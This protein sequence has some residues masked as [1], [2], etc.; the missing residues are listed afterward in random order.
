MLKTN[1]IISRLFVLFTAIILNACAIMP[2][3]LPD[4]HF[5][6]Q[7]Q[8]D[9]ASVTA[10]QD[11]LDGPVSLYEAI[12]RG[13]KYNLD[14]HLELAEK[15][16]SQ[17]D[18]DVSQYE[19]LPQL[20]SNLNYA[21]RDTF[22]GSASRSLLTGIQSLQTS[23]SSDRDVHSANL[24]LSWNVLDFGISYIRAKQSADRVLMAEEQK[25]RVVN[26]L[27]QD[28]RA[29]YWRAVS[30][31]RLLK[32][33]ETLLIKV[34]EALRDSRQVATERRERPLT[35]LT[36]QRE[37]I[38]IKREL[39]ELRRTLS[40]AKIQLAALMNLAPGEEYSLVIPERIESVKTIDMS[41]QLMEQIALENRPEIRE[42]SYE[43]RINHMES[44]AA[45]LEL[46]PG[47]DLNFGKNY[48]SNSFLFN[49]DWLAYGAQISWNLMNIF[50]LPAQNRMLNAREKVLDAQRLSLS[51]AVLTQVHVSLAQYEY[52]KREFVIANEYYETQEAI[53]EQVS[54]AFMSGSVSNQ[55]LIREEMNMLVSE[56]KYDIAYSDLENSY[57]AIFSALGMDLLPNYSYL[58]PLETL[59]S[60]LK[61]KLS[62]SSFKD[63]VFSLKID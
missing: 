31:D 25:R 41:P 35:A 21:G 59:E 33:M 7:A 32:K 51:M 49:N 40:L 5:T 20:V 56:I 37:L 52:S 2:A 3:P 43:K 38:S 26:R 11:A 53:L 36:Y 27:V 9:K 42:I 10:N 48:N 47:L 28:I 57:A 34:N 55:S 44:K 12:A 4:E 46:L 63:E 39:E 15:I 58:M 16:L 8:V 6:E 24:S 13:L 45:I 29:A 60:L 61:D 19:L 17:T 1:R 23:T 54:S 14:F 18:L 50:K 30:N 62:T 22:S